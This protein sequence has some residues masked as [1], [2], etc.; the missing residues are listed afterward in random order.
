MRGRMASATVSGTA[1]T[2]TYDS[3]G[4]RTSESTGT[5]H[6]YYLNDPNNPTGYTKAVEESATRG[7]TQNCTNAGSTTNDVV[8]EQTLHTYDADGNLIETVDK[9]RFHNDSTSSTG[10]LGG[11]TSGV[12]SR[13]Y[14]TVSYYDAANRLTD[15]VNVGSRLGA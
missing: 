14:Y 4:V 15:S 1:T 11:P 10:D 12:E 2:Y 13:N 5:T 3:G 9:Q 8:V 7:G 6:T